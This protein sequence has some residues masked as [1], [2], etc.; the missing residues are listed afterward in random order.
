MAQEQILVTKVTKKSEIQM[1][2]KPG[3][4]DFKVS[5]H[6]CTD[7]L[8]LMVNASSSGNIKPAMVL[9]E[10]YKM[11][12]IPFDSFQL[13]ITREDTYLNVGTDVKPEF[14]PLDLIGEI[15]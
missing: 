1:D 5:S 12:D 2:L 10:V 8:Y 6:D 11:L 4:Y 15:V 14:L 3:I 7:C 13:L 9:E